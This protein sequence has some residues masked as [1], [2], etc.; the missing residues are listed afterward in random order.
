MSKQQNYFTVSTFLSALTTIAKTGPE[1]CF[2]YLIRLQHVTFSSRNNQVL[3]PIYCEE[4]RYMVPIKM[5][6]AIEDFAWNNIT[7]IK[8]VGQSILAKPEFSVK[9]LLDRL[10]N[11]IKLADMDMKQVTVSIQEES[12]CTNRLIKTI[13]VMTEQLFKTEGGDQINQQTISSILKQHSSS[14]LRWSDTILNPYCVEDDLCDAINAAHLTASSPIKVK[15]GVFKPHVNA[16]ARLQA[17]V[18]KI[19]FFGVWMVEG[20]CEVVADTHGDQKMPP[21]IGDVNTSGLSFIKS[22]ETLYI[23]SSYVDVCW[24]YT[25]KEEETATKLPVEEEI[26]RMIK[27]EKKMT[28]EQQKS[29]NYVVAQGLACMKKND[30]LDNYIL[31]CVFQMA[32]AQDMKVNSDL[33]KA[34]SL[35][36]PNDLV[37][38]HRLSSEEEILSL[39]MRY[40]LDRLQ[41]QSKLTPGI[42]IN[43][44]QWVATE[45]SN[46]DKATTT[47]LKS[48]ALLC[49]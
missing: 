48:F 42:V 38:Q 41:A 35:Y 28:P 23:N 44:L 40:G 13:K 16:I 47:L 32:A 1:T 5:S 19:F 36:K 33:L 6:Q 27:G 12:S 31:M 26:V 30:A 20:V 39:V 22:I 17:Y 10:H 25:E 2:P 43:I 9:S 24:W 14:L 21:K 34:I 37:K 15:M 46:N 3:S 49:V 29:V 4:E 18:K 7:L 45:C 11:Y 8:I